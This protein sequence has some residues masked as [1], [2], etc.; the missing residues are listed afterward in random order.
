MHRYC[1]KKNF[2]N[3]GIGHKKNLSSSHPINSSN[4][5]ILDRIALKAWRNSPLKCLKVCLEVVFLLKLK[6][7][8]LVRTSLCLDLCKFAS[9]CVFSLTYYATAT[10]NSLCIQFEHSFISDPLLFGMWKW[11]LSWRCLQIFANRF[12]LGVTTLLY[13]FITLFHTWKINRSQ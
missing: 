11:Y 4:I 6:H 3:V 7:F 13:L 9:T 5:N 1:R 2:E 8:H 10:A 12:L